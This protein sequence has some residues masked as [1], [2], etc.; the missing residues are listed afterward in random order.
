MPCP[1]RHTFSSDSDFE[2]PLIQAVGEKKN[3][4]SGVKMIHLIVGLILASY[5]TYMGF[6]YV[7]FTKNVS[8]KL[9]EKGIGKLTIRNWRV[10][11]STRYS[12]FDIRSTGIMLLFIGLTGMYVLLFAKPVP[13]GGSI[14]NNK[15]EMIK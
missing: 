4:N 7:F 11:S 1:P 3:T 10:D 14:K 8:Q 2:V 5:C 12:F 9:E 6:K 13:K 15:T